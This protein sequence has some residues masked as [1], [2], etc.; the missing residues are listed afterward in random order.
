MGSVKAQRSDTI[1]GRVTDSLDR[2][3]AGAL[4]SAGNIK[5]QSGSG[6]TFLLLLPAT[7]TAGIAVTYLG[8]Q[9]KSITLS[10]PYPKMLH[11]RMAEGQYQLQAV[12]I[13]TGYQEI[14]PGRMTGS[15]EVLGQQELNR[16]TGSNILERLEGISTSVVFDKRGNSPNLLGTNNKLMIRGLTSINA[17]SQPLVVL[18]NFPYDGDLNNINPNDIE[19]VTLL[20]DAAAAAIWGARAGNGVMVITTKKGR[21]GQKLKLGLN[22]NFQYTQQP[23]L[24]ALPQQDAAS[25][26][27]AEEF[28]YSRAYFNNL[29]NNQRLP[30]VTPG[31]ELL[32]ARANGS[33]TNEEYLNRRSVLAG[34]DVRHDFEKQVYRP[35]SNQQYA[36][37]LSGGSG[38]QHYILTAGYDSYRQHLQ[39][40]SGERFTFRAGQSLKLLK[41][42]ELQ[43]ALNYTHATSM[44]NNSRTQVGYGQI[45]QGNRSLYPYAQLADEAGNPLAIEDDYR[46][47]SLSPILAANPF[48]LDW[49]HRP[50]QELRLANNQGKRNN[51]LLESSMN[52]RLNPILKASLRYRY[53]QEQSRQDDSYAEE[54]YFVRNLVNRFTQ[55]NGTTV[56]RNIPLGGI[57]D[58]GESTLQGHALRMQLDGSGDLGNGHH[59]S[60]LA[61]AERRSTHTTGYG[62]RQF[63]YQPDILASAQVNY[64]TVYPAF[65]NLAAAGVIP[66]NQYNS[67]FK[68]HNVSLYGQLAYDYQKRYLLSLS[69]RKDASNLFGVAANRKGTPLWSAGLAWNIHEEDFYH[70]A[71]ASLLKLRLS[72]GSAGNVNNSISALTVLK[73][74]SA[75][76]TVT[77]LPMASISSLPNSG[78]QW[79]RVNTLNMGLDFSLLKNRLSGSLDLYR[80][81][82]T[83]LLAYEP[84]DITT[85]FAL[86]IVNNAAT[87]G[88]GLELLLNSINTTGKL[89][90][91]SQLMM[92]YNKTTVTAYENDFVSRNYVS[93]GGGIL[94]L[95]GYPVYPLFSYRNGGLDP[96]TGVVR[97]VLD[98]EPSAN[99]AAITAATDVETLVFHGSAI[100]LYNGLLRNTFTYGAFSL[101]AT[102]A[103]KLDYYY[104]RTTI[105]YNAM[106]IGNGHTDYNLR[107]QQPGDEAF[108]QVPAFTYPLNSTR[109]AFYGN[110]HLLVERADHIRIQDV[111]LSFS[112]KPGTS[113]ISKWLPGQTELFAY[114]SNLGILWRAGT[115]RIDP[116]YGQGIP[117]RATLA[118]G[119]R[120]H[121]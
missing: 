58:I 87:K 32:V 41:N 116:D 5:V 28:L 12:T 13:S 22:Q 11:I 121:L 78:L 71:M 45:R 21:Y 25:Y 91:R 107:W 27:E 63:G 64:N 14:N 31:V 17:D 19:S 100:P 29:L 51:L 105:D 44:R 43:T 103:F 76:S 77:N 104:R 110:T 60:G 26:L 23:D 79:E 74:D 114:G 109:D 86:N 30:A 70:W 1:R 92:S 61:G 102:I 106:A 115:S 101:S 38:Q 95:E 42:V 90:W 80:K 62:F 15:A 6:G 8:Y 85:G 9:P 68:D 67:G 118:A 111:R 34:Q 16:A 75:N 99:Y 55:L 82:T 48:L 56:Q 73:Y 89:Q 35:A 112:P 52:W 98:G 7:G 4:L 117:A 37:N 10:R 2:P 20:K 57:H 120:I 108:T 47:L 24:F 54:S 18:D 39:T 72:Y 88:E 40:N 36:F 65:G 46:M 49:A 84:I 113:K 59:L 50:L 119:L 33:I 83:D 69:G 93:A 81:K 53:Q 96:Q 94:P 3:L 97:G 66:N